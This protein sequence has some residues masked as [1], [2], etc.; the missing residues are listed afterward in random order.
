MKEDILEQLVTDYLEVKGYFTTANVK[1]RPDSSSEGYNPRQDS[2]HSDIDVLGF[3]PLKSGSDRVVAVSCK[4]LQEGFDPKWELNAIERNRIVGGREAWRRY[5]ELA[6]TKWAQA[7][8][9]TVIAKTGV[10]QFTYITAVTH[11]IGDKSVWEQCAQFRLNIGCEIRVLTLHEMFREVLAS[12]T[13][14]TVANSELGRTIQLFRAAGI[15]L[16]AG[17]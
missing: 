5:R 16:S 14:T 10:E 1:F 11:V 7:F 2:V 4:S 12:L 15:T 6:N 13:G 9:A 17:A 3:H 8:R